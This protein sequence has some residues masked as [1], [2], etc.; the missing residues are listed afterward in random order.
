[1]SHF[2]LQFGFEL[3]LTLLHLLLSLVRMLSYVLD[4]HHCAGR[5]K[6]AQPAQGTGARAIQRGSKDARGSSHS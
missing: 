5:R 1:M 6:G 3:L 2:A 4:R